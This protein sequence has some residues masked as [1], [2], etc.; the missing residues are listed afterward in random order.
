MAQSKHTYP[1]PLAP[2]RHTAVGN[3]NDYSVLIGLWLRRQI[4]TLFKHDYFLDAVYR[5]DET[6]INDLIT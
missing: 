3:P 6:R 4:I 1:A 2:P 5:N